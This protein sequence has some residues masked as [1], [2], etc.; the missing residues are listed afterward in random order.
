MTKNCP[1][2]GHRQGF[3]AGEEDAS[4][5]RTAEANA[6]VDFVELEWVRFEIAAVTSRHGRPVKHRRKQIL[7]RFEDESI[8]LF[9]SGLLRN[10][11]HMPSSPKPAHSIGGHLKEIREYFRKASN[12]RFGVRSAVTF[13][14]S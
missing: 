2:H 4:G 13:R 12:V 10:C 5:H 11:C 7:D 3:G 8:E 1:G 9:Y 14:A 6:A